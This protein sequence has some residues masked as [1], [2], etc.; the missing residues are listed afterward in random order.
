[1]IQGLTRFW[2]S[3]AL[4]A[5]LM[6][7]PGVAQEPAGADFG[8]TAT[9]GAVAAENLAAFA[10]LYGFVRFFHP[11]E[12]AAHANWD[13]VLVHGVRRV[14]HAATPEALAA[15][16]RE[17]FE[18]LASTIG[19]GTTRVEMPAPPR[20]DTSG[21]VFWLHRGVTAGTTD[22]YGGTTFNSSRLIVPWPLSAATMPKTPAPETVD[23]FPGKTATIQR[24][25]WPDPTAVPTPFE[26]FTAEIGRGLHVSV[27]LALFTA[28]PAD[29]AARI[30][31]GAVD[32][33]VEVCD[34]HTLDCSPAQRPRTAADRATRLAAVISAWNYPQH[35]YPYF[36]VAGSDWE[37]ALVPALRGAAVSA[38]VASL[39][40]VLNRLLAAL[41]DGHA[42][43]AAPGFPEAVLPRPGHPP[44]RLRW[45]DDRIVITAV[46]DS[47]TSAAVGDVITAVDGEPAGAL[48]ARFDTLRSGSQQWVRYI[49]ASAW[50]RGAPGSAVALT[51]HSP[52][53]SAGTTRTVHVQRRLGDLPASP[54]LLPVTEVRPGLWYVDARVVT[55]S[56][57]SAALPQLQDAHGLVLDM[58]GYPQTSLWK[59]HVE[60]P[61]YWGEEISVP[62]LVRPNR[63]GMTYVSSGSVTTQPATPRLTANVVVLTNGSAI[64]A[65]ETV[66]MVARRYGIATIVG[67]ATAGANGAVTP[68]FLP[69]GFAMLFTGMRVT[70]ADGSRLHMVGV[71]PDIHASPTAVGIAEG[72]DEV[73]EAGLQVLEQRLRPDSKGDGRR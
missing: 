20:A 31:P 55:D 6:P 63:E 71:T 60:A 44:M 33:E 68:V 13:S 62:L 70:H 28:L 17:V 53:D 8:G 45:L 66:L 26:P 69:G 27:P 15:A 41:E 38:D 12:E 32:K 7:Q 10:R 25:Y 37:A 19:I 21:L 54:A 72:R 35:F 40:V 43:V 16:L 65:A 36:D 67:S 46:D 56:A 64:S 23:F 57:F 30:L 3:C 73:L 47:V 59:Y 58:R 51:V 52:L 48:V 2:R 29:A 4:I 50:L 9:L 39:L 14:E 1:M 61:L 24:E 42:R 34:L 11:S 5:V 22:P 49:S 18:P